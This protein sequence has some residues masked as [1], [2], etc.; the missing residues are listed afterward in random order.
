MVIKHANQLM[1]QRLYKKIEKI[2]EYI[3]FAIFEETNDTKFQN[4][5]LILND[6]TQMHFK[7]HIRDVGRLQ[8]MF[9]AHCI[10]FEL[11]RN[12]NFY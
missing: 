6:S 1:N 2:T 11:I 9:N 12:F 4:V 10:N 8:T 5:T 3:Q 7:A